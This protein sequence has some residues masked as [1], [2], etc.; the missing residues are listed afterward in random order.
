[1]NTILNQDHPRIEDLVERDFAGYQRLVYAEAGIFLGPQKKAL[2]V[3]RLARRMRE[4]G[5]VS[6]RDYLKLAEA[7]AAERQRLVEAVCTHET[8]FFRVPQQ[9]EHLEREVLP[10]WKQQG[11]P[12][13]GGRRSVRAWSA[14]CS[15]GEEPFTLAMVLH[16]ALPGWQIEVLATD[17]STRVLDQARQATW[18][19]KRASEIPQHYLKAYMLRGVGSQ[20]GRMKAGPE[21]RALVQFERFNLNDDNAPIF[22]SFD[23]IFCRNVLI[24]FD[25]QS[26]ERAFDRLLRHL[27]PHGYLFLGHAESLSNVRE[28]VRTVIPAVYT[29]MDQSH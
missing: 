16:H 28:R 4:L 6:F 22:G 25:A 26:R 24:Y 11:A 12:G 21:L 19:V 15:T 18:P 29:P 5:G 10:R 27:A 1:M 9:F 7:D 14:G 20:E 23:L 2:L 13:S 3:G 8:H 17:F